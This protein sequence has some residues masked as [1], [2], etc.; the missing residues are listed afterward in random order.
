MFFD[1]AAA[2]DDSD[3]SQCDDRSERSC[4]IPRMSKVS[5][6]T[7][8]DGSDGETHMDQSEEEEEDATGFRDEMDDDDGIM[9][10]AYLNGEVSDDDDL[11]DIDEINDKENDYI[12]LSSGS[13]SDLPLQ[14]PQFML[15][16]SSFFP[17]TNNVTLEPMSA[18]KAAV[19]QFAENNLPASDVAM[20]HTTL[21]SLQQQQLV[22]LQ[23]IQQLQQQLL[24]GMSGNSPLHNGQLPLIAP[25]M[26]SSLPTTYPLKELTSCIQSAGLPEITSSSTCTRTSTP[27]SKPAASESST[28]SSTTTPSLSSKPIPSS[29]PLP[30]NDAVSK[31]SIVP[32]TSDFARLSMCKYFCNILV[33]CLLFFLLIISADERRVG[34]LRIGAK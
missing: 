20:L 12:K 30:S 23:L 15:P 13:K 14:L 24:L 26:T 34:M 17:N 21:Y 19:A 8:R 5:D 7:A 1:A 22:Q 16:F 25:P 6:V 3:N 10:D 27:S 28:S 18:T 9:E 4:K 2:A 33:I 11:D 31:A 29:Q 32:E